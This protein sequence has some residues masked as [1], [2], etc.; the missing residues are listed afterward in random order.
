MKEGV[1]PISSI[2]AAAANETGLQQVGYYTDYD[3]DGD[4]TYASDGLQKHLIFYKHITD[5]A[6]DF[7]ISTVGSVTGYYVTNYGRRCKYRIVGYV[8]Q[9]ETFRSGLAEYGTPVNIRG[10]PFTRFDVWVVDED[11]TGQLVRVES[12][13][14][15]KL[16]FD[17]EYYV[18][19]PTEEQLPTE[20]AVAYYALD[21]GGDEELEDILQV[22]TSPPIGD[23]LDD[24]SPLTGSDLPLWWST[25]FR[26][27]FTKMGVYVL[28]IVAFAFIGFVIY[29]KEW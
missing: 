20:Y 16:Q 26:L 14:T 10:L 28:P 21:V 1:S 22:P 7:D 6:D 29:G 15:A 4:F 13:T 12:L 18:Q 27:I 25:S 17:Y 24:N 2:T 8:G 19:F 5:Y 23:I 11:S 3:T 9:N